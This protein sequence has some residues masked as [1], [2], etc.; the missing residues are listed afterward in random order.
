MPKWTVDPTEKIRVDLTYRGEPF[1]VE[2]KKELSMGEQKKVESSALHTMRRNRQQA[3]DE[4][5]ADI[6][7]NWDLP[8]FVKVNTYLVDWSLTDDRGNKLP[9]TLDSLK[10]MRQPVFKLIEDAVDAH[11]RAV[12]EESKNQLGVPS[13]MTTLA[14]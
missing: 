11:A 7:V 5:S 6:N 2:L 3:D 9:R 1:W 13:S 14:S 12:E 10:A 4:Q 8:V